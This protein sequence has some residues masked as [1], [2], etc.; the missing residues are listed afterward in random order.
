[1]KKHKEVNV[2]NF[3]DYFEYRDIRDTFESFG[4]LINRVK[5]RELYE[6]GLSMNMAS[7]WM[8]DESMKY[9]NYKGTLVAFNALVVYANKNNI[10]KRKKLCS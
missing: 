7:Q 8:A 6:N 9:E 4:I 2:I 1:M 3:C 5:L 10:K